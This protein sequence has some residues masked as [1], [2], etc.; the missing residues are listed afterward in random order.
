MSKKAIRPAGDIML[1]M[2]KLLFELHIDHDMQHG[3]VLYLINGWQKIHVPSQIE[4]YVED[5]THPVLYGP[6]LKKSRRKKKIL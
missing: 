5:G 2:E 3:E 6:R 4:T 1:D